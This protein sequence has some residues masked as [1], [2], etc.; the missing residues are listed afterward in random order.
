MVLSM[1]MIRIIVHVAFFR[2]TCMWLMKKAIATSKRDT[3][4]VSA[5]T[6]SRPE[7]S[8]IILWFEVGSGDRVQ[9]VGE[10]GR[11]YNHPRED[12]DCRVEQ[13]NRAGGFY[14]VGFCAEI[15]GIG[16]EDSHA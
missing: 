6:V 2:E 9:P 13:G 11:E 14:Q 8:T 12:R 4:E 16:D 1:A 10:H 3:V 15:G 5:A 7:F